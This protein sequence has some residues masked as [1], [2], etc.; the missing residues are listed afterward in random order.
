MKRRQYLAAV[1][2]GVTSAGCLDDSDSTTDPSTEEQQGNPEITEEKLIAAYRE[3]DSAFEEL[4]AEV[5]D[6][7]N[8]DQRISFEAS[9]IE[10]HLSEATSNLDEAEESSSSDYQQEIDTLR[11][12]VDWVRTFTSAIENFANALDESQTAFTYWEN[13]RFQ[14]SADSFGESN[15]YVS[16]AGDNLTSAEAKAEGIDWEVFEDYNE[17]EQL[18]L[19]LAIEELQAI[20]TD[21]DYFTR[22]YQEMALGFDDFFTAATEFDNE[23]YSSAKDGFEQARSHFSSAVSISLNGEESASDVMVDEFIGLTCLTESMRD[24]ADH[25][26]SASEAADNG[27]WNQAEEDINNAETAIDRCDYEAGA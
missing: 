10:A 26:V 22:T 12:V 16:E 20:N 5:D 25:F 1:T 21:W 7:D 18:E 15:D 9:V 19:E 14:D 13:E 11:D 4:D 3:I 23:Q 24:A 8:S 27:Q 6:F 17:I 2:A